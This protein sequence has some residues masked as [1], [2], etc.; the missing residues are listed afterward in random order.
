MGG[1][2]SGP[3]PGPPGL[4]RHLPE[5]LVMLALTT[6][7]GA[8]DTVVHVRASPFCPRA[9]GGKDP[10]HVQSHG[11]PA[12][13]PIHGALYTVGAPSTLLRKEFSLLLLWLWERMKKEAGGLFPGWK[14]LL[15]ND[16]K[17]Y[18]HPPLCRSCFLAPRW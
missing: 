7:S 3:Q 14:Q 11:L 15:P 16:P 13:L 18:F 2:C 10:H 9:P 1:P 12:R 5:L 8:G 17:S 4:P 6:V